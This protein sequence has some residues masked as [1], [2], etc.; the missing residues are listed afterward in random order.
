[1]V[2][3]T[4]LEINAKRLVAYN[5]IYST[6]S[7]VYN[8]AQRRQEKEALEAANRL[9]RQE[10]PES[11][12][13]IL[14]RGWSSEAIQSA[15]ATSLALKEFEQKYPEYYAKFREIKDKHKKERRG[16]IEFGGNISE[17][18]FIQILRE[19]L[20]EGLSELGAKKSYDGILE[21]N[22]V[23]EKAQGIQRLLLPQ[24]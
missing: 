4:I 5:L 14:R 23:L 3:E 9:K 1:M 10:M 17:E 22:K 20:G 19:I 24:R 16:Y 13:L 21:M 7:S 18:T 2:K 6:C 11:S 15:R 8:R 12:S